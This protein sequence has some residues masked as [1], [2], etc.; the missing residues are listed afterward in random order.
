VGVITRPTF[1]SRQK[2]FCDVEFNRFRVQ[3]EIC[4]VSLS[5]QSSNAGNTFD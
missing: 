4:S 2:R 3:L 5:R 1:P